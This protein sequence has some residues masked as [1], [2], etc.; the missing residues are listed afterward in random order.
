VVGLSCRVLALA[1]IP[2]ESN[3]MLGSAE[4]CIRG[5]G[6]DEGAK[7]RVLDFFAYGEKGEAAA[8]SRF[9]R[10]ACAQNNGCGRNKEPD[11]CGGVGMLGVREEV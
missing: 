8:G 7:R 9:G 1:H 4:R 11:E 2:P 3:W 6:A 10:T 5:G